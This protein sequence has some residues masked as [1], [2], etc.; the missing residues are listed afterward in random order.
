MEPW[1]AY[2]QGQLG[3]IISQIKGGKDT[4]QMTLQRKIVVHSYQEPL[5]MHP[6]K[7]QL[8]WQVPLYPARVPPDSLW[9]E[10]EPEPQPSSGPAL[11]SQNSPLSKGIKERHIASL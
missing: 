11:S 2:E 9:V 7:C 4:H 6:C 5:G 3:C 10:A 1:E 8:R